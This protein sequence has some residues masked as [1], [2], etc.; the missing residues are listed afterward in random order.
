[1][2]ILRTI[3]EKLEK[4]ETYSEYPANFLLSFIH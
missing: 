1:M 2:Q 3:T 4:V